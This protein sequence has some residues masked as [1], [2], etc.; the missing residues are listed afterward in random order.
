MAE[1]LLKYCVH[2]NNY[3]RDPKMQARSYR[4]NCD[5]LV[6]AYCRR[7][8]PVSLPSEVVPTGDPNFVHSAEWHTILGWRTLLEGH[9]RTAR[10]YA[11]RVLAKRPF[12][13]ESWRLIY[14]AFRGY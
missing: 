9:V 7:N 4:V 8:L 12:S 13:P 6:D 14:C 11:R 1:Y 10:K 5:I 3:S 2:T